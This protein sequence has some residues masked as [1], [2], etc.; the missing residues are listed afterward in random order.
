MS[1]Q[2]PLA[3]RVVAALLLVLLTACHNWRATFVS[4]EQL[5]AVERPSSVRATLRSGAT[6]TLK[7]PTMLNG[8]LY[9]DTDARV[10]RVPAEDI[11]LLEVRHFSVT[12][13]LGLGFLGLSVLSVMAAARAAR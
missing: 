8:S 13:T 3:R 7:N 10:L 5:I 9:G 12:K 4:P 6:V 11:G 1:K 2:T